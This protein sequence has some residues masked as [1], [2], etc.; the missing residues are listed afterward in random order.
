MLINK[1]PQKEEWANLVQRPTLKREEISKTIED[2][3]TKVQKNGDQALINFNKK[4]DNIEIQDIE[5]S[6]NEIIKAEKLITEDLKKAIQQAKENITK[7]HASQIVDIQKIETTKG[8][9][10]WRENRAIE[11]VGI[12]IPGGTAPLFSTVLMLAI[13]A[14][15][16]GC[17]EVIL[18]SPPDKNGNI[19]PAILYTAQLCGV[20]KIFKTGGAQAIAAM[21]FGTES[22]PNVYK[23]FGPGNQ[24]V[25]AAKEFAQN[26][27]VAIDMPAGP[28]E[29]LVI[30]DE[31]ANPDFCAA[32]L[33]SQAEHGSDS[34][35]I[36]LSTDNDIF[37]QTIE[38]VNQQIKALP[39]NEF[40]KNALK[41]SH[42][43][44]INTIEEAIDFSNIYAPEHLILAVENFENYIP[45]IQN[46]GSV[47]LGN[48][49]CESA[50]DYASGTNHTLPTNGFAKN[51]SGVSLDSFVK[52]I[53]FQN[54]SKE[55]IQ[56]LGKTIEIMAEAEGLTAHKN[57][58][59]IRLKQL[60]NDKK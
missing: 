33:L 59:S 60:E 50:G 12:Y 7:F 54:L 32:D 1:Y 44:L 37:N 6:E 56:N 10:C 58:V 11:K 5:V 26:Y 55:G 29:V 34:Q 35:V 48:Y 3:F 21:T 19:N 30:A 36:F 25:V 57:A 17:K 53:T 45:F 52:K 51:Y 38:E 2:I 8:V 27:G 42:F 39:R 49:S 20:T 31:Q 47:F 24:Y 46:A 9:I 16:A 43:I 40:A 13:P 22:I 28:S 41:S 4:F 15:L 14:Q 18:C 23:I